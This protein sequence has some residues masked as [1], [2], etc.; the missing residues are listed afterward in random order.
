MHCEN[1]SGFRPY[2]SC[3]YQFPSIVHEIYASFDCNP[4]LDVRAVSLDI[5]KPLIECGMKD[6]SIRLNVGYNWTA[7]GTNSKFSK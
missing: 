4:P 2:D 7:T 6:S 3:E 1:Q 5:S